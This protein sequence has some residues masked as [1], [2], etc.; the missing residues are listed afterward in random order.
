[1]RQLHGKPVCGGI[2][3]GRLGFFRSRDRSVARVSVADAAAEHERFA[4]AHQAAMRQVTELQ[5]RARAEIG[6]KEAAVFEI[7]QMM[8]EDDDYLDAIRGVIIEQMCNAEYAVTVTREEF[9]RSFAEM[10]D[11][12]LQGRAADVR[13]ISDRLLDCLAGRS[14]ELDVGDE[15][16]IVAAKDL[17]PSETVQM[18]KRKILAFVTGGGSSNSHTAI[19]ARTM[20]LPAV[21]DVGDSLDESLD[22]LPVIVDGFTGAIYVEPDA[23]TTAAMEKRRVEEAARQTM[24]DSFRGKP[25]RTRDG[26]EVMVYANIGSV[27]EVELVHRYDA[28]GIGLFRS[29]FLFLGSSDYPDEDTQFAAYRKVA[30]EMGGKRSI[31]RTVDIGA[32]KQIAY[33]ALDAEE[34][35]ALGL[36]GLRL[37]LE[38]PEVFKTQLRALVRASAF[39]KLAV[40]FPMVASVWEVAEAKALLETVR[41]ELRREDRPFDPDMEVGVMIETPAAAVISDI[42]A[43]EVDFLSLGTNDLTQ[44]TLAVDRQNARLER[45]CDPHHEAVLRLIRTV[46]DNAHANNAWVGVCGELAGDTAITE[47]LLRMGVDELSVSPPKVLELRKTIA[48][49]TVG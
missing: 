16:V 34:N 49:C 41:E 11:P 48:E 26:K 28:G 39:G 37:C 40:M 31:I 25:N 9:A 30:K 33:F 22:G 47:T 44:Y 24:L 36:R 45:F 23:E 12:Y 21:V 19:L 43:R 35:P 42:L 18:D 27:A 4:A 2:A 32:D 8:L 5:E 29:E 7:H 6:D 14:G 20:G 10:D 13:D 3:I 15:P 17:T 38:R 46:V 1:M